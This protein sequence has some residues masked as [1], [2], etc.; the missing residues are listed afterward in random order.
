MDVELR[1]R[2]LARGLDSTRE[3]P[4]FGVLNPKH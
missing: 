4:D 2:D 1:L 3:M